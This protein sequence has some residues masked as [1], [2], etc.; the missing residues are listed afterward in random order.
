LY[1][2]SS[3]SG[4]PPIQGEE[5][6]DADSEDVGNKSNHHISG[7]QDEKQKIERMLG[8]D[9]SSGRKEHLATTN[10]DKDGSLNH[11]PYLAGRRSVGD[12]AIRCF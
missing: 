1:F 2:C 8:W 4:S 7:V 9:S 3:S 5:M 10:Y 6:G 11:I 12:A